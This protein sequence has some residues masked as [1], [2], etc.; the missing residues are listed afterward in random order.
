MLPQLNFFETVRAG[1]HIS[2]GV[3]IMYFVYILYSESIKE[4]YCGQTNSIASRMARHNSG[5]TPRIKHGAPWKLAGYVNLPSRSEAMKLEKQIK[6]RGIKR[7]LEKYAGL[8]SQPLD[9]NPSS[10]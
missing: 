3:S 7:W 1:V 5:E 8:L 4:F 10:Y 9:A 6:A 2:F